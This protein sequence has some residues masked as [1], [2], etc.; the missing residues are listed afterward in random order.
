VL[1]S[2]NYKRDCD[3]DYVP[4][5][6]LTQKE[7]AIGPGFDSLS[8]VGVILDRFK[9]LIPAFGKVAGA[10]L[11]DTASRTGTPGEIYSYKA[12]QLHVASGS[13]A[14]ALPDARRTLE[15][16]I[17]L[18]KDIGPVPLVLGCRYVRKSPALLA[19]NKFDIGMAISIDG[20]DSAGSRAFY[21]AAADRLEAKG[22]DYT[23][24]WGKTNAYTADRVKKAYGGNVRKWLDARRSVL[25]DPA[26][27]SL[28]DN[29]Y[30]RERGL[31]E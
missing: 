28:F 25:P 30:I 10:Q 15:T 14:V 27:R 12:P 16:L 4:T 19:F 9:G 3:A 2:A 11:F 20:V 17:Q 1:L 6:G 7:G 18:Y 29:A 26:D 24:H 13:I 8:L 23:Q 21:A 5:Y 22:V 31:A